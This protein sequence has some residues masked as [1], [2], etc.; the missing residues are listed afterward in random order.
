MIGVLPK[1]LTV[2]GRELKIN[3][4]FRAVLATIQAFNDPE[5]S[6]EEKMYVTLNNIYL[7][8]NAIKTEDLQEA[9]DKA[10]WFI[11]CGNLKKSKNEGIKTFDWEHDES[12]LFPAINKVAGREVRE[13]PY[14][15]WWTFL[16][17][18]G[19]IGEG[20]FST[21]VHIRNKQAK[22]KPLDTWEREFV[23]NN[24]DTVI[25]RTK[26][27]QAEIDETENFLKNLI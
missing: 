20:L 23:R 15:H 21:V 4:D 17:Y 1:S 24:K 19:E 16:G 14:L 18:F 11:D 7:R 22:G 3:A 12:I 8:P 27:E 9:V 2:G 25:L 13:L 6:D 5:L 10:F 26:E